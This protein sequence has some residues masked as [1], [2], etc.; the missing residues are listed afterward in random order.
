MQLKLFIFIQFLVVSSMGQNLNWDSIPLREDLYKVRHAE[1]SKGVDFDLENEALIKSLN[2]FNP[3]ISFYKSNGITKEQGQQLIDLVRE[4]DALITE[5]PKFSETKTL[6]ICFGRAIFFHLLMLKLGVNKKSIKK[7]F[8]V[9]SIDSGIKDL[10]WQF[11]TAI[12]VKDLES[13]KWWVLDLNFS[14]PLYVE[15]WI[16]EQNRR[17]LDKE[18]RLFREPKVDKTK[19][20]RY[21]ITHPNKIGPSGW[22][23]NIK[24][25]GL[26]DPAY[27][28]Y[29][30]KIFGYLKTQHIS[31][32]AKLS[33][34][35]R[36]YL[37][38]K[39]F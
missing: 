6:G 11:H 19:S 22:E 18:Y 39:I 5:D 17:A 25:G 7:I 27:N 29:F 28:N 1:I 21:Y 9:G 8:A 16:H 10:V 15:D 31:L 26:F 12:L 34:I 36:G 30:H 23:Y 3:E 32:D 35:N 24:T 2:E 38:Q 13:N 14:E 33:T 20:I 37:C 4:Q